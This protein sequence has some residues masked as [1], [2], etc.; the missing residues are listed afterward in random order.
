MPAAF[1]IPA[2]L[3]SEVAPVLADRLARARREREAAVLYG[4]SPAF[5][6]AS[7]DKEAVRRLLGEFQDR[8]LLAFLGTSGLFAAARTA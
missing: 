6:H 3:A 4:R 7:A 8:G 2:A 1:E 5:A